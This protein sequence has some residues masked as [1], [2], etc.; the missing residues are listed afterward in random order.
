M[1]VEL[2]YWLLEFTKIGLNTTHVVGCQGSGAKAAAGG[3]RTAVGVVAAVEH[4][5]HGRGHSAPRGAESKL[6]KLACQQM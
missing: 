3:A 2:L 4:S 5:A 6:E 1:H